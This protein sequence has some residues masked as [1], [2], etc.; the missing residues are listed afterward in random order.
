MTDVPPDNRSACWQEACQSFCTSLFEKLGNIFKRAETSTPPD[1]QQASKQ[2]T[3][4]RRRI[5]IQV[6]AF[7]LLIPCVLAFYYPAYRFE[8]N[9]AVSALSFIVDTPTPYFL[10][11]IPNISRLTIAGEQTLTLDGQ[12]AGLTAPCALPEPTIAADSLPLT[13]HEEGSRISI[14]SYT[15]FQQQQS[16]VSNRP[17][18]DQSE[19]TEPSTEPSRFNLDQLSLEHPSKIQSLRYNQEKRWLS[20]TLDPTS[21]KDLPDVSH[22]LD[23]STDGP[24]ILNIEG[25]DL[26]ALPSELKPYATSQ[27]LR[28][29][30]LPRSRN[31][32][33]LRLP[34]K[35]TISITLPETDRRDSFPAA[36]NLSFW[37]EL[38]V[39]DVESTQKTTFEDD[40]F[41]DSTIRSGILRVPNQT[42]DL[43]ERQFLSVQPGQ[44]R[45]IRRLHVDPEGHLSFFFSGKSDR[46]QIGLDPNI[47]LKVLR[48]SVLGRVLSENAI[49]VVIG[50]CATI[51]AVLITE[52]LAPVSDRD[53]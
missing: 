7:F 9:L 8:G 34:T 13:L 2:Q 52:I 3:S 51:L 4:R 18:S 14:E 47:P 5:K 15:D 44:I 35:T 53:T 6:S 36:S 12:I 49:G 27:T 31:D 22:R 39:S 21:P 11:A 19:T 10:S 17:S 42:I 41:V 32:W 16:C 48:V 33:K 28:I 37:P 1:K 43:E 46:V 38:E 20:F 50:F 26:N 25:F 23:L 24:W 40:S 29:W 45:R 30:F